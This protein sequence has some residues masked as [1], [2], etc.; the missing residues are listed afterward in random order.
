MY[1]DIIEFRLEYDK[2]KSNGY[3]TPELQLTFEYMIHR[4]YRL[5]SSYK[6]YDI[7]V[8]IWNI[9]RRL[10][11]NLWSFYN[12]KKHTTNIYAY[13]NEIIK[14]LIVSTYNKIDDI[15]ILYVRPQ[16]KEKLKKIILI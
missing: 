8:F 6:K 15:T 14:R 11:N 2:S 1:I 10:Q 13:F 16:R 12:P 9:N 4:T 5:C 7:N 3:I